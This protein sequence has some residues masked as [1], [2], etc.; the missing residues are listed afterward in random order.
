VKE[1]IPIGADFDVWYEGAILRADE[2]AGA[3]YIDD[4]TVTWALFE[5][6]ARDGGAA[7]DNGTGSL[8]YTAASD[9]DYLGQIPAAVTATLAAGDWYTVRYT[10][11]SGGITDVRHREWVALYRA[12][13]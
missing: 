5:G 12:E 4:A 3:P 7:V 8:A 6:R 13:D 9:G 11:T 1:F 2:E 10:F